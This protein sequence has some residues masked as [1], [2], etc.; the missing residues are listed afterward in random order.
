MVGNKKVLL[1]IS[2]TIVGIIVFISLILL[3]CTNA[4]EDLETNTSLISGVIVETAED[5]FVF[6]DERDS[7]YEVYLSQIAE[8][9][10]EVYVVGD[11]ITL[12]FKGGILESSPAGFQ[13]IV[14]ITKEV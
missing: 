14:N 1:V 8:F 5:S 2:F 11:I 3:N 12:Y 7:L 4:L 9:S 6:Q 10:D 13:E